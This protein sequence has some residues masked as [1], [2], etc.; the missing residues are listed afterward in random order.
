MTSN[1]ESHDSY[2]M[3]MG[4]LD[5]LNES[6]ENFRDKPVLKEIFSLIDDQAAGRKFG[7][8]IYAD[9]PEKPF[10]YFTIRLHNKRFEIASRGKDTP[11]IDWKVSTSYLEDINENAGDYISNPLKFDLDWLKHRLSDAA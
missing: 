7:V 8:A 5:V 1:R 9:D 10:D 11:D 4:A 3:F 6:I 2:D